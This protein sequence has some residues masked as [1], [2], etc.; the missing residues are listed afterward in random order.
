MPV[1][2]KLSDATIIAP[3]RL[4]CEALRELL[5]ASPSDAVP[6]LPAGRLKTERAYLAVYKLGATTETVITLIAAD[7]TGEL[8]TKEFKSQRV[9]SID[10]S[11]QKVLRNNFRT[12]AGVDE[13]TEVADFSER[14][15]SVC[16]DSIQDANGNCFSADSFATTERDEQSLLEWN[17]FSQVHSID[18]LTIL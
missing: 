18:Y 11:V 8:Y 13:I 7:Q 15:L 9:I 1:S 3:G 6:S 17:Q 16:Y 14:V 5:D 10:V 12:Q 2:P 4:L